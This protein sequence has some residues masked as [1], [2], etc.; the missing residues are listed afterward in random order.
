MGGGGHGL[1]SLWGFASSDTG[2]ENLLFPD[3]IPRELHE[4]P[5]QQC[6]SWD[7]FGGA[8]DETDTVVFG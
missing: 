5:L 3:T 4:Y 1:A 2:K 6:F 8:Y 7:T